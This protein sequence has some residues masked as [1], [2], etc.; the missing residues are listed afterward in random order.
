MLSKMTC[1]S[2]PFCCACVGLLSI[3]QAKCK[4]NKNEGTKQHQIKCSKH[5]AG[6]DWGSLV[7]AVS[8]RSLW[9]ESPVERSVPLVRLPSQRTNNSRKGTHQIKGI[10]QISNRNQLGKFHYRNWLEFP[11]AMTGESRVAPPV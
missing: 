6:I 1:C 11:N 4:G 9:R 8:W 10:F 7:E 5:P 3:E 2:H